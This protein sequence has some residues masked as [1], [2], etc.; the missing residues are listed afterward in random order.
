MENDVPTGFLVLA[1][2][3]LTLASGYGAGTTA[4]A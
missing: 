3:V 4:A 2:L 1:V